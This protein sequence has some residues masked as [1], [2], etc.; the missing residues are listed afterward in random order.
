MLCISMLWSHHHGGRTEGSGVRRL[1]LP[2][3]AC[4][5]DADGALGPPGRGT[6]G[7]P[8]A[9]VRGQPEGRVRDDGVGTFMAPRSPSSSRSSSATSSDAREDTLH[10]RRSTPARTT[11]RHPLLQHGHPPCSTSFHCRRSPPSASHN[12]YCST[13]AVLPLLQHL[14]RKDLPP[15]PTDLS[16]PPTDRASPQPDRARQ[17]KK[18]FFYL[19]TRHGKRSLRRAESKREGVCEG[20]QDGAATAR[21]RARRR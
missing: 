15:P 3:P 11:G 19:P 13:T 14:R 9:D 5:L 12:R 7:A 21:E 1:E 10:A 8:G 17:G 20:E 16:P 6:P 4:S 2:V 18:H